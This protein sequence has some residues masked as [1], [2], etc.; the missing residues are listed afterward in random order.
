MLTT[1]LRL[2]RT[3]AYRAGLPGGVVTARV[4][5]AQITLFEFVGEHSYLVKLVARRRDE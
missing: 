3:G 5:D 2:P 4:A 1:I